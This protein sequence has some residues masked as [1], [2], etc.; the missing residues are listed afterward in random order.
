MITEKIILAY[1]EMA[2]RYNELI[3]PKPTKEFEKLD[4]KDYKEL[5]ERGTKF[6]TKRN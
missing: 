2:E 6:F 3:E 5:N 4:P 1:E